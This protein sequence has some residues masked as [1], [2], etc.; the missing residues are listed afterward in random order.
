MKTY[1]YYCLM[2]PA[3]PG[4]VPRVGWSDTHNDE[5]VAPSGHHAWGWVDYNRKL[6]DEEIRNYELEED[7]N[8]E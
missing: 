8:N 6:T 3:G 2:R 7:T 5:C 4:A 1:R